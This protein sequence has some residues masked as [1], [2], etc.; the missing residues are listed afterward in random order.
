MESG[1]SRLW[2]AQTRVATDSWFGWLAAVLP[3]S[4][5]SVPPCSLCGAG[6]RLLLTGR[7]AAA[8]TEHNDFLLRYGESPGYFVTVAREGIAHP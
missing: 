5:N 3:L 2:A 4:D 6:G 8:Q 1:G 7:S